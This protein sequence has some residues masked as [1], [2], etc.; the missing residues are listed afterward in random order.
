MENQTIIKHEPAHDEYCPECLSKQPLIRVIET[1]F[2][3]CNSSKNHVHGCD[4]E[5]SHSSRKPISKRRCENKLKTL[6]LINF[7][8][9][10]SAAFRRLEASHGEPLAVVTLEEVTQTL[11]NQTTIKKKAATND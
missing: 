5:K 11:I 9:E 1:G 2:T 4:Y 8:N 6:A 10:L 3:F 7:S